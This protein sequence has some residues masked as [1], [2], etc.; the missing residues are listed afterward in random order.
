MALIPLRPQSVFSMAIHK[1]DT[2][3][4]AHRIA[5]SSDRPTHV[6]SFLGKVSFFFMLDF[7]IL[8]DGTDRFSRNVGRELPLCAA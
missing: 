8:A 1:T 3:A 2:S 6:F 4:M 5:K 7:L